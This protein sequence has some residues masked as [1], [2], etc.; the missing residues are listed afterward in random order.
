MLART[1]ILA[2]A[3]LLV[4][5]VPAGAREARVD[6]EFG[7]GGIPT[8]GAPRVRSP[9]QQTCGG[10]LLFKVPHGGMV[11]SARFPD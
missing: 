8:D 7:S 10:T 4:A 1:C 2:V 11:G 3:G 9:W 5:A 6:P